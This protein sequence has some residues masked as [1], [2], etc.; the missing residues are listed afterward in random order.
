MKLLKEVLLPKGEEDMLV[1]SMI[2][3]DEES[4]TVERCDYLSFVRINGL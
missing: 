3:L 4:S 2:E 1:P